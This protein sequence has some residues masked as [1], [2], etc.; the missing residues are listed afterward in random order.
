MTAPAPNPVPTGFGTIAAI[1]LAM[2]LIALVEAAIP[3]HRRTRW[4]SVHLSPN[5]TLTVVYFA[6]GLIF[7]AGL[8]L[9]LLELEDRQ[10][11]MLHWLAVSPLAATVVVVVGLDFAFYAAHVTMHASPVLWRFH[12]VHHADPAVDVTTT[13]RQHPGEAVIR[14]AFM[15]AFAFAV[16]APPGALAIYRMWSALN[17]LLE[18]ANIRMPRRLDTVLSLVLDTEHAQGAPLARSERDQHELR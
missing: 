8:V 13:I 2:A 10:L 17:G 9:V 1:L 4:N 16:G 15:A 5:L 12:S 6:T 14:Y 11:G 18:H 7:N 3:L